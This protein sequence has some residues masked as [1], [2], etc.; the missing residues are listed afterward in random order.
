MYKCKIC[1]REF[2]KKQGHNGH[3]ASHSGKPRVRRKDSIYRAV[4]T[5]LNKTYQCKYCQKIFE[6]PGQIGGH[7]VW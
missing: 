2:E 7:T 4:K 1:G 3:Q 5:E 6:R